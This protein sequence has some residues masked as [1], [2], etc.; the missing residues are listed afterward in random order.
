MNKKTAKSRYNSLLKIH[1]IVESNK[2]ITL[3][4]L[5]KLSKEIGFY[6]DRANY[7]KF[8]IEEIN[9][10]FAIDESSL[11]KSGSLISIRN[12]KTLWIYVTEEEKYS[13][14]S[15][16][17]HERNLLS[18]IDKENDKLIAVGK[19]AIGFAQKNNIEILTKF[20]KNDIAYLSNLLPK[21]VIGTFKTDEYE[22]L[23]FVINSNKIK[24]KYIQLLPIRKNNFTLEH[25]KESVIFKSSLTSHK[26][27]QDLNAFIDSELENYLTFATWSLLTE[28]ALI[29]EKYKLVAQ[30]STLNDLDE[31]LRFQFRMILKA[32]RE[33]EIEEMSIL[34]KKKDLLHSQERLKND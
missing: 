24:Q 1:K 6:L 26:I 34:S 27:Y 9:K 29:Y 12:L 4:N 10:K 32:K 2:N 5:L 3:I 18:S 16:Q 14:N 21:L 20:E 17:K 25:H 23:N 31:K 7:S 8:I 28:S 22:N 30:N 13:T 19:R 11:D 15:Y 33:R